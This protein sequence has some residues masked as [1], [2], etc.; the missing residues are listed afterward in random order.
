MK[1]QV[2]QYAAGANLLAACLLLQGCGMFGG[3][4]SGVAPAPETVP[5]AEEPVLVQPVDTGVHA[6]G[7]GAV[8]TAPVELPSVPMTTPYTVRK[9]DTISGIAQRYG[10]RWQDVVAVNPGISPRRLRIGQIIQLNG[11]VD[12]G[13]PL[14]APAAAGRPAPKKP[15]PA[16]KATSVYTVKPGDSLSVIAH[17]HGVRVKA[18]KSLNGL[19]GDL[20]RVGQK[21]KIPASARR[22]A[23]APA[24]ALKPPKITAPAMTKTAKTPAAEQKKT[25]APTAPAAKPAPAPAPD[26]PAPAQAAPAPAPAEAQAAAQTP[27]ELYTVKQ[28]DDIYSIAIRWGVTPSD[29]KTLNNLSASDELKPGT[30]LKIPPHED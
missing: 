6:P 24:P 19:K 1:R 28:G 22:P 30:V 9:G 8:E 14:P 26:A 4:K 27:A 13:R 7:P 5:P 16:A 18:L 11:Q 3:R 2:V 12:L 23:A 25:P 15:A 29:L 20:I 17:R 10:L 21:L